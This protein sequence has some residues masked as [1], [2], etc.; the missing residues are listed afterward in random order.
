MLSMAHLLW[1]SPQPYQGHSVFQYDADERQGGPGLGCKTT[2]GCC[3]VGIARPPHQA[4]DGMAQGGHHLRDIATP[5]LG[6]IF[7][8]GD[9][10]DPRRLV[11]N[12]PVPAYQCEQA[13]RISAF[14][15]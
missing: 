8:K 6:A 1:A 5:H 7:I 10:P 12:L 15:P 3:N 9:I 2:A 11:L 13:G 4:D 14:W